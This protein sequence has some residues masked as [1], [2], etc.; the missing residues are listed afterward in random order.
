MSTLTA[1]IPGNAAQC[2]A[3]ILQ[4]WCG[5]HRERLNASLAMAAAAEP[6]G[7]PHECERADLLAGI[8][9][10]MRDM[11]ASGRTD[12]SAVFLNLLRHLAG[13]R[14]PAAPVAFYTH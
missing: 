5:N 13:S 6:S 11:L 2:A 8:A 9:A 4:A 10:N 1:A 7:D 14:G 3:G 12:G